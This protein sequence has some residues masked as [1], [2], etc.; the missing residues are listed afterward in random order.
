MFGRPR[1]KWLE[2]LRPLKYMLR[3]DCAVA[4]GELVQAG[5]DLRVTALNIAGVQTVLRGAKDSGLTV[6]L[7]AGHALPRDPGSQRHLQRALTERWGDEHG[8]APPAQQRYACSALV[9]QLENGSSRFKKQF[10]QVR[11]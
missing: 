1:P 2:R 3:F 10:C 4:K 5:F 11:A 8:D 9:L 6:V 7:G